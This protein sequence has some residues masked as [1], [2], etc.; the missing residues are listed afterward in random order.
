MFKHL[1]IACCRNPENHQ[2][3]INN[4]HESL[5]TYKRIEYYRLLEI[6]AIC[7]VDDRYQQFV[8]TLPAFSK[9]NQKVV[10][11]NFSEMSVHVYQV[12]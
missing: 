6:D 7:N 11:A 4:H 9:S 2:S 8:G 10:G 1:T 3:L 5:K 12:T